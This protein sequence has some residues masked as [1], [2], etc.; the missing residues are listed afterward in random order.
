MRINDDK[1]TFVCLKPSE[2]NQGYMKR[3]TSRQQFRLLYDMVCIH[4]FFENDPRV[5]FFYHFPERYT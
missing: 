4:F 2:S 5:Q 1:K 3:N